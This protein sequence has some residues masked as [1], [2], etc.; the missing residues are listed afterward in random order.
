MLTYQ[1][2]SS[3]EKKDKTYLPFTVS[4]GVTYNKVTGELTV[5]DEDTTSVCGRK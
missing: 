1:C 3:E 2:A 5:V 4:L